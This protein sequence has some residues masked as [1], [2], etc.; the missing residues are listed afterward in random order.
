[1]T[2]EFHDDPEDES[3]SFWNKERPPVLLSVSRYR[4]W[5]CPALTTVVLFAL[6]VALA[7]SNSRTWNRLWSVDQDLSIMNRS[8]NSQKEMMRLKFAVENNKDT[9]SSV[10]QALQQLSTLDSLKRTVASLRCSLQQIMNNGSQGA[11]CCPLGWDPSGSSCYYFSKDSLSW[12]EARDHCSSMESQLA[13]LVSDE[14]WDFV[15]QHATRNFLWIGLSDERTGKWEWINHTPYVMNRRRW[16]PGQPDSWLGH[17]LGTGDEDCAHLHNDGRLNDLHC[18][19]RLRYI[20][21]R[22]TQ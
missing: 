20:C 7:A 22:H 3:S 15:S 14:D 1:M 16:R 21:Q 9:L 5:A 8:L 6:I 12:H 17:G 18:S 11:G 2:T 19:T 13:I 4:R 10:S